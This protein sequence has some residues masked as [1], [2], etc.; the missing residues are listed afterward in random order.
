[1]TFLN[2]LLENYCE[3]VFERLEI[4][5]KNPL[6]FMQIP[7]AGLRLLA[8]PNIVSSNHE[9]AAQTVAAG[10]ALYDG[11]CSQCHGIQAVSGRV[12]SVWLTK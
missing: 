7:T 10:A 1:M 2:R 8:M 5:S 12:S 6:L 9:G 11:N 4:R 3:A